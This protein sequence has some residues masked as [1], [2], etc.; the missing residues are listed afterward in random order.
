MRQRI[1]WLVRHQAQRPGV[2]RLPPLQL[3]R[4]CLNRLK[5][6][7]SRQPVK[8]PLLPRLRGHHAKEP[9]IRRP[10]PA[11]PELLSDGDNWRGVAADR[12]GGRAPPHCALAH[13]PG[14]G[15]GDDLEINPF[16][17]PVQDEFQC[18]RAVGLPGQPQRTHERYLGPAARPLAGDGPGPE[19]GYRRS[20]IRVLRIKPAQLL[21]RLRPYPLAGAPHLIRQLLAI[22]GDVLQD[23]FVEQHR[24]RVQ[25]AGE[26]IGT[27]AQGFQGYR[28]S[29]GEG[30]D[31][32]WPCTRCA[33]QRLV[34]RLGKR[35]GRLQVLLLGG[36]VPVG[37]VG[38]EVQQGPTQG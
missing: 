3:L 33:S 17:L 28:A 14:P 7:F 37:E 23:N 10:A 30:I 24:H 2:L 5:I 21:F 15:L 38:D 25:V 9:G 6:P 16:S 20:P 29:P 22:A 1:N 34:R 11:G 32:Q 18:H 4:R 12:A 31:H 8:P 19:V 35:P 26:G 36:V 13:V 27:D